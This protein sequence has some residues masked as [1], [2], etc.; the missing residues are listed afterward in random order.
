M[1]KRKFTVL[2]EKGQHGYLLASVAE[3]PGCHTQAKTKE[4][5][6][7]RVKEAIA[8]Y[9]ESLKELKQTAF[10]EVIGIEKVEVNA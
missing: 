6:M 3:L 5:L 2:I 1:G 4:E 9:L 8:L 10:L 7:K